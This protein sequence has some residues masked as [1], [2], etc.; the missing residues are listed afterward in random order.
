MPFLSVKEMG[1][2]DCSVTNKQERPHP[3]NAYKD[4]AMPSFNQHIYTNEEDHRALRWVQKRGINLRGFRFKLKD[5]YWR[6]WRELGVV[7]IKLMNKYSRLHDME[8]TKYYAT[9]DNP[10]D[11]PATPAGRPADLGH[12]QNR[13]INSSLCSLSQQSSNLYNDLHKY[14][15]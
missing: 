2:L 9:R 7:L 3:E 13:H 8:I 1:R 15:I 14:S 4:L 12:P 5:S 11:R 6:T 10:R